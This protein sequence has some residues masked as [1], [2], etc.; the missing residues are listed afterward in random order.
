[1]AA[2]VAALAIEWKME[3]FSPLVCSPELAY[4][5]A[6]GVSSDALASL[7]LSW[8]HVFG[9][10]AC[11]VCATSTQKLIQSGLISI[12][13]LELLASAAAVYLLEEKG[14][15]SGNL[16][17]ALLGDNTTACNAV[18][19]GISYN[20]AI[21][22]ALRIIVNVCKKAQLLCWLMHISSNNNHIADP[23]SR[24]ERKNA[25]LGV[26]KDSWE[27]KWTNLSTTM[28]EW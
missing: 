21:R 7:Q 5:G 8:A 24:D 3:R 14:L 27:P 1:M 10:L 22:L 13:P 12:N 17:I 11:G 19:T 2:Y 16:Q 26:Q 6:Q 4:P 23:E 9:K 25:E 18:N 28:G 15:I 20:P